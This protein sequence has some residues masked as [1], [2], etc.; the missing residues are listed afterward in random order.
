M[1]MRICEESCF[2]RSRSDTS[3]EIFSL[4]V[5]NNSER[6]LQF[7]SNS[8]NNP[9]SFNESPHMFITSFK[10]SLPNFTFTY[11]IRTTD[12]YFSKQRIISLKNY[13]SCKRT[14]ILKSQ[15]CELLF[16]RADVSKLHLR[17]L[18]LE[19]SQKSLM[20]ENL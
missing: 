9:Y 5:S 17:F 11:S 6:I 13:L 15:S 18:V 20:K 19:D 10:S 12:S 3:K 7:G 2:A 4:F 1:Y 14:S 16:P 8:I